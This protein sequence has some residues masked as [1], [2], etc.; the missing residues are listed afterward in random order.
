MYFKVCLNAAS[1]L[2]TF[3]KSKYKLTVLFFEVKDNNNG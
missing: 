2:K 1:M 3:P